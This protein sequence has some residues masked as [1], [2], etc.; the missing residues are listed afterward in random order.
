MTRLLILKNPDAFYNQWYLITV[1][2]FVTQMSLL[3]LTAFLFFYVCISENENGTLS[4]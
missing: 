4:K 2:Q 1:S 3:V